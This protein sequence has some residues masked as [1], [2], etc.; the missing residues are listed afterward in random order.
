MTTASVKYWTTN[1][2]GVMVEATL[3]AVLGDGG[4]ARVEDEA[5]GVWYPREEGEVSSAEELLRICRQSP[6]AGEWN[7]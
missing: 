6:E 7:S 3:T 4:P 5:G 1:C 2:D